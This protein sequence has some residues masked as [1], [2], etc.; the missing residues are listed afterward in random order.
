MVFPLG[1]GVARER[2]KD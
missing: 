1:I 2:G